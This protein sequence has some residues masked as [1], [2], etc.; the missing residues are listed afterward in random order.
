MLLLFLFF[1]CLIHF[2]GIL[3]TTAALSSRRCKYS[4]LSSCFCFT[5][6]HHRESLEVFFTTDTHYFFME[7]SLEG[8]HEP[9]D[10]H[11]LPN[12]SLNNCGQ[13][14]IQFCSTQKPFCI[15]PIK[16]KWFELHWNIQKVWKKY[17]QN[18]MVKQITSP[19]ENLF[20]LFRPLGSNKTKDILGV[21]KE[22]VFGGWSD[23]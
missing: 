22:N 8:P 13:E 21:I 3:E 15:T 19:F 6:A 9:A 5:I 11:T 14:E 1:F 20:L 2:V 23:I 16:E 12:N 4:Q 18:I 17:C 7:K 10:F